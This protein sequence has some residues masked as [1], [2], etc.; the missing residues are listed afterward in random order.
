MGKIKFTR[1][2][3]AIMINM[4]NT[5]V[6]DKEYLSTHLPESCPFESQEIKEECPHKT[7]LSCVSDN[8]VAFLNIIKDVF[9]KGKSPIDTLTE[10]N[11]AKAKTTKIRLYSNEDCLNDTL[12][13]LALTDEQLRLLDYLIDN[14]FLTDGIGYD[15]CGDPEFRTI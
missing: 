2:E 8:M 3:M 12:D 5:I 15:N 9:I 11:S 1:E 7:C 10:E 14:G 13:W 6:T 4:L